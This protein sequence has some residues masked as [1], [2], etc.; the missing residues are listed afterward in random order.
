[1]SN[2]GVSNV[3]FR[4]YRGQMTFVRDIPLIQS[5]ENCIHIKQIQTN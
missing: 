1:M 2:W 3:A 5:G 4:K